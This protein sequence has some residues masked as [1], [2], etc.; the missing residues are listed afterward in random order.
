MMIFFF[1]IFVLFHSL[2]DCVSEYKKFLGYL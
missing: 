1:D 2:E